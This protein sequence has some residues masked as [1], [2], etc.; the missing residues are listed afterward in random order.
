MTES[1]PVSTGRLAG[2]A[3]WV[4]AWPVPMFVLA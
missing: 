3:L 4:A 2:T 1:Q